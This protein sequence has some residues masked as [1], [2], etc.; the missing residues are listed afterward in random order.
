MRQKICLGGLCGVFNEKRR[1]NHRKDYEMDDPTDNAQVHPY[2]D[3][4]DDDKL[5]PPVLSLES[6]NFPGMEFFLLTPTKAPLEL[7]YLD[8]QEMQLRNLKSSSS[9]LKD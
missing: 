7:K 1:Y 4:D 3:D 6:D 9:L 5:S 8:A 2:D